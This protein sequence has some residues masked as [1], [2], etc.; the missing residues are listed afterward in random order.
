MK[1][2][3]EQRLDDVT[4]LLAG[5]D[6]ATAITLRQRLEAARTDPEDPVAVLLAISVREQIRMEELEKVGQELIVSL[7]KELGRSPKNV[8]AELAPVVTDAVRAEMHQAMPAFIRSFRLRTGVLA[9]SGI[10]ALMLF[11]AGAGY[12]TGRQETAGVAEAWS[13][14]AASPQGP[15]WLQLQTDNPHLPQWIS[16]AC[17][18]G[19]PTRSEAEGGPVCEVTLWAEAPVPAPSRPWRAALT[20]HPA[21]AWFLMLCSFAF[22]GLM[23]RGL[24]LGEERSV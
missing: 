8:T 23:A 19:A 5:G 21:F 3:E 7:R 24:G 22:G 15:G 17:R 10:M 13:R 4:T 6:P 2:I 12:I 20:G 1:S 9:L 14:L 18:P 16:D 11:G